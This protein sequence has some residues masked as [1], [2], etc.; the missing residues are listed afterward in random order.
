MRIR[1]VAVCVIGVL[2]ISSRE[3]MGHDAAAPQ[4]SYDGYAA[5]TASKG[6]EADAARFERLVSLYLAEAGY[7]PPT[8]RTIDG[9]K[10]IWV[11]RDAA[12]RGAEK[13]RNTARLQA[14]RSVDLKNLPASRHLDWRLLLHKATSDV[15]L[16]QFP[17]EHLWPNWPDND[18]SIRIRPLPAKTVE[19]YREILA[20]LRG[21]AISVSEF[22]ASLEAAVAGRVIIPRNDIARIVAYLPTVVPVEPLDSVFLSAFK[23]FSPD[24][25]EPEQTMLRKEAERI[26]RTSILPAYNTYRDFLQTTY[27]VAAPAT[28]AM[29]RLP[30]GTAWYAAV[31][32]SATGT[33]ADPESIHQSALREVARLKGELAALPKKEGFDGSFVQFVAKARS[34]PRCAPLDEQTTLVE[35]RK[36]LAVVEQRLPQLFLTIPQTPYEVQPGK[37]LPP[38]VAFGQAFPGSPKDGRPGRVLLRTPFPHGCGLQTVVLHEALPG[39]I[40]QMHILPESR[41]ASELIRRGWNPAFR[42]GWAHYASGLSKEL[43]LADDAYTRAERGTAELFSA[44]QAVVET[45]LHWKRWTTEE[46]ASYFKTTL[47]WAPPERGPNEIDAASASPASRLAYFLGQQKIFELRRF[48]EKEL[49]PRFDIRTFHDEV[50]RNG[51][52]PLV[53]LDEQ[54]RGW[55]TE[56]KRSLRTR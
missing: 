52:L 44:V 54:I 5:V 15:E 31:V 55:V 36:I 18:A 43:G 53:V 12:R 42:E 40:L 19:D 26:Y 30:E 34:D 4:S 3:A 23:K 27:M 9:Q 50:L 2:S 32:R 37:S 13:R 39:H 28:G 38:S 25:P 49:G 47:P 29:H 10:V 56:T 22:V 41:T 8:V 45:G 7:F 21:A 51:Q 6:K 35:A 11:P 46:A 33:A 14:V 20:W 1:F 24:I 16:D 17:L 48:A